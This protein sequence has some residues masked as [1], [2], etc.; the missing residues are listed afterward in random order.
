MSIALSLQTP[1]E[2]GVCFIL[3]FLLRFVSLQL[4]NNAAA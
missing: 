3:S 2:A 1:V 4:A